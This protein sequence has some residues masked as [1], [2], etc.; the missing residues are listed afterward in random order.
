MAPQASDMVGGDDNPAATTTGAASAASASASATARGAAAGEGSSRGQRYLATPQYDH[1]NGTGYESPNEENQPAFFSSDP[2]TPHNVQQQ[3]EQD[4]ISSPTRP[5]FVS[6]PSHMVA[7]RPPEMQAS[8]TRGD[9]SLNG[10]VAK[11][12][13]NLPYSKDGKVSIK[14]RIACYQWTWFTM[15]SP[16]AF[17]TLISSFTPLGRTTPLC[18]SLD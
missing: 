4:A 11:S 5:Q 16:L 18:R 17:I 15:V 9:S 12:S 10:M 2:D 3:K 8:Q 14:D 7:Y 13:E 6:R 1:G